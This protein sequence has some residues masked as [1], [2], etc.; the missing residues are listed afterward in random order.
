[1]E[2]SHSVAGGSTGRFDVDGMLLLPLTRSWCAT[3]FALTIYGGLDVVGSFDGFL[4]VFHVLLLLCVILVDVMTSSHLLFFFS[5]ILSISFVPV[6]MVPRPSGCLNICS[7][8]FHI[9]FLIGQLLYVSYRL[10]D[11]S[12]LVCFI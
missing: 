9:D 3:W 10:F 7:C 6:S 8:M 1:M 2:V 5:V 12:A 11:W 4:I